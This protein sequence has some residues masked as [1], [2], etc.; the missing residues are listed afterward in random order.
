MVQAFIDDSK[1]ERSPPFFVLG[2]YVATIDTWGAFSTEW[3]KALDMRPRLQYFKYREAIEGEG[4]FHHASEA[5]RMERIAIMRG[6]VELFDLAEFGIAFRVD[7]YEKAFGKFGRPQLNPYY[8]ATSILAA[9]IGR[10]LERLQLPKEPLDLIFDDQAM[11]KARVLEAWEW[12]RNQPIKPDALDLLSILRNP[13]IWRDD[14]DV[15]P[16]QAADM[17]A[18]W[19]RM[20]G[21]AQRDGREL[22][23]MPGFKRQ[24]RGMAINFNEADLM[25]RA[26]RMESDMRRHGAI[27][28]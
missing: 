8:F 26:A 12:A 2:G 24:I 11:E 22:R 21:E 25:A 19:L 5:L 17:H 6:V 15:L 23:S 16:L 1:S 13:P 18:T 3:Q 7:S 27:F 10:S 20:H 14:K 4:E 9:E 28:Y